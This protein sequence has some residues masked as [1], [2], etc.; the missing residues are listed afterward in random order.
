MSSE[1]SDTSFQRKYSKGLLVLKQVSAG[2][3]NLIPSEK[4]IPLR[5]HIIRGLIELSANSE[6]FV[7]ILPMLV[8]TIKLIQWNRKPTVSKPPVENISVPIWYESTLKLKSSWTFFIA[9]F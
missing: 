7:P 5:L 8:G 4:Y 2:V 6:T 3:F 9:Y 1:E